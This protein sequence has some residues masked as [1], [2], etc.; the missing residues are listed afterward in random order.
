MGFSGMKIFNWLIENKNSN[1]KT[2]KITQIIFATG[3][4]AIFKILSI[5]I[6]SIIKRTIEYKIRYKQAK[7]PFFSVFLQKRSRPAEICRA[8]QTGGI[9]ESFRNHSSIRV[10]LCK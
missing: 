5:L 7:V 1:D 2:N 4:E 3:T 6:P 9:L 10:C 8:A